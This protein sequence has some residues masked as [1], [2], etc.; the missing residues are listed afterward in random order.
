MKSTNI[1]ATL[2]A[3]LPQQHTLLWN[4][5]KYLEISPV[6]NNKPLSITYDE[7]A[8]ELP[9]PSIRVRGIL[10]V[11]QNLSES[12]GDG[13]EAECLVNGQKILVVTVYVSPNTPSYGCKSLIFSNLDGYSQ[14]VCKMFEIWKGEVVRILAGDFNVNVKNNYNAELVIFMNDTFALDVLSDLS[15]ETTRSK[16]CI[17]MVFGLNVD[18]LS[19]MNYVSYFSYHR[20]IL[21]TTNHKAPQLTDVT[22]S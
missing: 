16:L 3:Y 17:D 15:Q 4:E 1:L 18:N 22:T 9:F 11:S 7:H 19:C 20:P 2:N 5:D 13:C 21:N 10:A 6:Q 8:E 14:K 12:C